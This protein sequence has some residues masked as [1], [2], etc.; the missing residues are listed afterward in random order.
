[1]SQGPPITRPLLCPQAASSLSISTPFTETVPC[2]LTRR[3]AVPGPRGQIGWVA[4]GSASPRAWQA[5][6]QVLSPQVFDPLRFS[7]ENMAGR[8]PFAFLPFSA[9]PR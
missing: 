3:Y 7:L 4:V 5:F 1:M 2:G 6:K 9:G 8:H